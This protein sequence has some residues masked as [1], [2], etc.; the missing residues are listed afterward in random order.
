MGVPAVR[1]ALDGWAARIQTLVQTSR[2]HRDV[3][4]DPQLFAREMERIFERGWIYVAHESELPNSGDYKSVVMGR[5]PAIISRGAD[6]GVVRGFFN[7]CRHRGA[8]VCEAEYGAANYFRCPYH[9]WT[10]GNDGRLVGV[11]FRHGYDSSFDVA[12]LGLIPLAAVESFHGF[13]FARAFDDAA[14]SL[15]SHL[16]AA[17]DFLTTFGPDGKC[18]IEVT[19][20][21]QRARYRANWK[22]SC[23]NITDGYH[24]GF[25]HASFV[26]AKK[27][28]EGKEIPVKGTD[29]HWKITAL[30][31]G[32]AVI[33]FG[34]SNLAH[35]DNVF[36]MLIFP[37]ALFLGVSVRII[38][39]MAV[40]LTETSFFPTVVRGAS[41]EAT[42]ARLR[43]HTELYGPMGKVSADD[44]EMFERVQRGIEH[45]GNEWLL[46]LRGA[47][48]HRS[49]EA[50][51]PVGIDGTDELGQREFYR[52][53]A[54]MMARQ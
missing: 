34:G 33:D 3:Y 37:N 46:F 6:D 17:G 11:P 41:E 2:V 52:R 10:Y 18:P 54:E 8:T 48:T 20:P 43:G 35:R 50:G 25:T 9:G 40:N 39:P 23:E 24:P 29:P 14:P 5:V 13:I 27:V 36:N 22:L 12:K 7:S 42:V 19:T 45:T 31:N 47:H 32:H 51:R 1:E 53:Y 44:A 21:P 15:A 28:I 26:H 49:D 4:V 16:A 30:G 38:R